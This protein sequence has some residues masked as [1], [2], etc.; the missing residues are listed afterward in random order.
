MRLLGGPH[1]VSHLGRTWAG[2]GD[3]MPLTAESGRPGMQST[4]DRFAVRR[5]TTALE[6]RL[7]SRHHP[8]GNKAMR[9][10]ACD[11]I[12]NVVC[13][14]PRAHLLSSLLAAQRLVGWSRNPSSMACAAAAYTAPC[15]WPGH[16]GG[17]GG[18]SASK[19]A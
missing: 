11:P 16:A 13:G 9:V 12:P 8:V 3:R 14:A 10:A 7:A 17:G 1:C 6:L 15:T 5:G 19:A 2:S 18:C 4:H